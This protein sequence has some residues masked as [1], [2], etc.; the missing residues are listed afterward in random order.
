[1][2][3]APALAAEDERLAKADERLLLLHYGLDSRMYNSTCR[4]GCGLCMASRRIAAAK[5]MGL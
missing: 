5:K 2:E 1:V 4:S 3:G